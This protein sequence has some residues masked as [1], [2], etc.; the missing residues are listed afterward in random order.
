MARGPGETR[1]TKKPTSLADVMTKKTIVAPLAQPSAQQDS[2]G[3]I[4]NLTLRLPI[5]V[6]DQLREM[7]YLGRTSQQAL[8]LEALNLLFEK[9]GK[10]PIAL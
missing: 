10:P 3:E 4:K 9:H 6:H 1:M 7:A 2:G 5:V 8:L